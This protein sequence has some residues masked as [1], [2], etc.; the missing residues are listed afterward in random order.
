MAAFSMAAV[1]GSG[2]PPAL[3]LV[4]P[5]PGWPWVWWCQHSQ[6]HTKLPGCA[7]PSLAAAFPLL[8]GGSLFS[9]AWL[10]PVF[11]WNTMYL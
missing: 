10:S 4:L 7:A 6:M 8:L 11:L 9:P 3:A 2:H 5:S 1:L